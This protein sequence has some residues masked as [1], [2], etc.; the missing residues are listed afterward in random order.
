MQ[1]KWRIFLLYIDVFFAVLILQQKYKYEGFLFLPKFAHFHK[2]IIFRDNYEKHMI[3]KLRR[4]FEEIYFS[5]FSTTKGLETL[6]A[7]IGISKNSMR[8]FLGKIQDNTKLRD[9]TLS[10]IAQ[11]LGYKDYRD[12][13]NSASREKYTLDFE[14]LDIYYGI[15]KGQGTSLNETRFQIANYYF[16]EK[17]ISDPQN[18]KEF[19]K[20]FAQNEEA[21]EYV[22]AWHPSYENVAHKHYQ[23]ALF[24]F[25]KITS[26]SHVK[27][28]AIAFVYFGKFMSENLDVEESA[29]ILAQIEKSVM[30]MRKE[31]TKFEAFPEARYMIARSI[32]DYLLSGKPENYRLPTVLQREITLS[33]LSGIGF[34]ERFIYSTYVTNIL[35]I[36]KDYESA[37]ICFGEGISDK[38]LAEFE[39]ENHAYRAHVFLYRLERSITLYHLGNKEAAMDIFNSLPSD[40]NNMKTFSFDSKMYFEIK[41]LY[42]AQKIYP[43]RKDIRQRFELL[44]NRMKFSYLKKI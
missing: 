29:K 32:H 33:H 2:N 1:C 12:F 26:K 11:R 13:C 18:L 21:L 25:A 44:A 41:Y 30:K 40:I 5:T 6:A 38:R 27:V 14:L 35:N 24:N 28:F 9:S 10:L 15:V 34:A 16:A 36:V 3:Q 8:R 23:E 17:I 19:V 4:E 20:R 43:K 22:L 39:I 42:F 31:S 7:N 37:D